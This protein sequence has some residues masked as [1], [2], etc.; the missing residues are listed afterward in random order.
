MYSPVQVL[1]SNELRIVDARP[2][3]L[4]G[5]TPYGRGLRLLEPQCLGSPAR[6]PGLSARRRRLNASRNMGFSAT[7]SA[8]ALKFAGNC[9]R[10]FFHHHGT[11]PQRIDTS[12]GT[13]SAAGL[14]TSTASVGAML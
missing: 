3:G 10:G 8:R 7:L 11:S 1:Q 4:A 12:S 13:P 5:T 9:F 14:T 2:A 6:A